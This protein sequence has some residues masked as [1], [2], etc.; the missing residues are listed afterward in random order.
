MARMSRFRVIRRVHRDSGGATAVEY[1]LVA[2][3][4]LLVFFVMIEFGLIMFQSMTL[5][6][7]VTQAA[8]EASIGDSGTAPDRAT[9]VRQLIQAKS[10]ALIGDEHL[11]IDAV[12]IGGQ[13]NQPLPPAP[14]ICLD[15]VGQSFYTPCPGSGNCSGW[16]EINGQSGFQC[17]N[18]VEDYGVGEDMVQL[19]V[20]LPWVSII[21]M[22]GDFLGENGAIMLHATTI[23]K[24]EPFE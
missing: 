9:Y 3:A 17:G 24:N 13:N 4:F 20:S 6:T 8:R 15:N 11:R 19:R 2:P 12:P 23:V 22:L 18:T 14:D 16:E 5:E 1:A 7:I 10:S 21:P